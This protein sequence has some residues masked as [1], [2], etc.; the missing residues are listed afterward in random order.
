MSVKFWASVASAGQYPFSS[1][2]TSC[3]RYQQDAFNQSWVNVGPLSVTLAHIQRGAKRDT[4][5]QYWA[6]VRSA[7]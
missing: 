4:L 5:T 1:G 7:S 2:S 3:W 6:N